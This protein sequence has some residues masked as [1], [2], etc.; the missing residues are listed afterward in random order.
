MTPKTKYSK[1]HKRI[2][3]QEICP[4]CMK[5]D[6]PDRFPDCECCR[7]NKVTE[8]ILCKLTRMD[9]EDDPNDFQC[10]AYQP[11]YPIQ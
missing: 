8:G 6:N 2:K 1:S 5:H 4:S 9:Q 3:W 10:G 7:E 11:K